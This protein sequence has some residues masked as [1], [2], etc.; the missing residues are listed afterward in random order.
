MRLCGTALGGPFASGDQTSHPIRMP[1]RPGFRR[2]AE[3]LAGERSRERGGRQLRETVICS[4]C[5]KIE[6]DDRAYAE[7]W[8]I[9]PV[10]CPD[11][12]RWTLTAEGECCSGAA[13]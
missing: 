12:L 2:R 8:Q 9:E 1:P 3:I 5:G 13:S 6:T 11:C 4:A 7:G 10:V